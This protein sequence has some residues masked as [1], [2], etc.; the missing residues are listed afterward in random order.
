MA[1]GTLSDGVSCIAQ[2]GVE[3][4]ITAEEWYSATVA[5]LRK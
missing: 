2:G 4:E 1:N 5:L 3:A